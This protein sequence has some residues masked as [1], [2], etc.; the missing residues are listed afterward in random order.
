MKK[1]YL[2][3]IL[4]VFLFAISPIA[5]DNWITFQENTQHTGYIDDNSDFVSNLWIHNMEGPIYSSPAILGNDIFIVNEKGL[6]KSIDMETGDENWNIHLNSSTNS[7]PVIYNNTLYI[8]CEEGL[9]AI[10]LDDKD[11]KW[12]FKADGYV[13]S[14][15]YIN[16]GTIYFGSDNGHLYG[17]DS[18]GKKTVDVKLG[19]KIQSSPIVVNDTVYVG[20]TDT[21]FYSLTLNGTEKW[22]F[23][24]GDE[25]ISTPAYSDGKVLFGS[26]DG[27]FYVLDDVNGSL[28][29]KADLDDQVT[30]SATIEEYNNN[31]FI[32]SDGG[33]LTCLDLRDGDIKWSFPTGS[34]VKSTPA[35]K[36]KV[37]AFGSDN[38]YGYVLN[39]YTGE[40]EF[41]YNPGTILFNSEITS[42]PVIYGDSLFFAGHDGYIYSLNIEKQETPTAVFAYYTLIVC[43]AAFCIL[44][45]I[46]RTVKRKK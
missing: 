1:S 33:N 36:D 9:K 43:I 26:N 20:S 41:T 38:G 11:I 29:W 23:S 27:S 16:N 10:D 44:V 30:A 6:L 34:P 28:I 17:I 24:T 42:S 19:G 37:V 8:G 22:T 46:L 18:N 45:A 39:K 14:T 40:P 13:K 12:T 5:A 35:I 3:I 32:G 25:I 7:S 31:V 21:K 4:F 15:P 2:F